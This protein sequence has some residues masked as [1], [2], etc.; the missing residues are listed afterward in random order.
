MKRQQTHRLAVALFTF[1]A[2]I[3]VIPIVLVILYV[4]WQG[5]SAL[6]WTFLTQPPSNGM[7]EGG[8]MPAIVGTVDS[9]HRHRHCLYAAG[10]WCRHLPGRIRQGQSPHAL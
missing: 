6:S 8:I 1:V 4:F 10:D 3:V 2:A 9:H 5:L 7:T